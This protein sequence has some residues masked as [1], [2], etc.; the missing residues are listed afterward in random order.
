MKLKCRSKTA[1]VLFVTVTVLFMP[2]V[3]AFALTS[4]EITQVLTCTCGCNLLVSA[5][6]V[7]MK[8]GQSR[9]I[10]DQ[11][12]QM[13][14]KGRSKENIIQY[15]VGTH[16]E[17]ILAAPTKEG[18]NLTA[19]I[20]PFLV[21]ILG[22]GIIYVFIDKCLI[23]RKDTSDESEYDNKKHVSESKYLD[24]FEKELKDFEL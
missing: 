13:I 24:L 11:V 16:G 18:F 14:E 9:E 23:S 10:I 5:C 22:A 15:F 12:S 3:P 8:C 2:T 6:A 17:K 20:L 1:A 21:I 4:G 7:S 19:W